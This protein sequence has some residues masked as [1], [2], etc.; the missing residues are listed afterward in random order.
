MTQKQ[1]YLQNWKRFCSTSSLK[2]HLKKKATKF[3]F[4]IF[5]MCSSCV[6]G[7]E[8]KLHAAR[9]QAGLEKIVNFLILA[10]NRCVEYELLHGISYPLSEHIFLIW[11]IKLQGKWLWRLQNIKM[12]TTLTIL[13]DQRSANFCLWKIL[14]SEAQASWSTHRGEIKD[15]GFR[16]GTK[17]FLF[18]CLKNVIFHVIRGT[19]S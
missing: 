10:L 12:D 15:S 8:R 9:L 18:Q 17:E 14:F 5:M 1:T 3:C 13:P 6:T 16:G 2:G 11:W 4:L 19:V 7:N